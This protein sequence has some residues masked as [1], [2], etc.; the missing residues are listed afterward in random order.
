MDFQ[1][2]AQDACEEKGC[3]LIYLVTCGSHAYGT[4]TP[5]SDRDIRGIFV[6]SWSGLVGLD[7]I[8]QIDLEP[9]ICLKSLREYVKLAY[10]QNPNILDWLFVPN[11]CVHV[12]TP[13]F[14]NFILTN[15]VDF[16]SRKIHARFK[17]YATSHFQKMERGTTRDLGEK[18]KKDIEKYGFSTKNAM[19]LVR[20][21]RMG[22]EALKTG[23]YN[24]YREDAEELLDIRAGEWS[25]EDVKAEGAKLMGQ[26]DANLESSPLPSKPPH[27]H[28]NGL[29]IECTLNVK[30]YR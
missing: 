10:E 25:I 9:D 24:V 3:E 6:P 22:S 23:S 8:K 19:H 26:L 17:G 12:A 18:R 5:E 14:R 2:A 27:G 29:L 30:G 28:I 7:P 20:L 11:H 1:K 13:E 4:A 15:K 21:L 16:L